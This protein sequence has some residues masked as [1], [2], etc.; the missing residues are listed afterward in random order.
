MK[1]SRLFALLTT[2]LSSVAGFAA[3]SMPLSISCDTPAGR[4]VTV[5]ALTP[6]IIRVDNTHKGQ[7]AAPVQSVLPI[8]AMTGTGTMLK[9]G[10]SF[11]TTTGVRATLDMGVL[12][13]RSHGAGTAVTDNLARLRNAD[14]KYE[15]SLRTSGKGSFYGA[16][17]RGHSLNLRGDTLVMY[18]RQNYGYTGSDPRISQMNITM[19]LFLS[20]DGYAIVFDD[21]AAAEL[22]LSDPIK[23]ITESHVPVTYYY[24]SGVENLADLTE[25]LTTITGRQPLPPLW[26]L[27]YITS[28]YGYRTQAQTLGTVDTLKSRGYPLDGIVLDLYWYGVE[29]DMGRLAW[30]PSQWPDH[31]AMLDSLRGMGVNLVAISQ[32][33]VLRNGRAIDNYN[34]LAPKGFF[35][36]DSTG[37]APQEVK[38]WVGEG[39]MFDVSNPDTRAWLRERYRTLTDD[40]ITGWWGDLGEPEVHPENAMHANGLNARL[41]HNKYGNDWS[42]IISELFATEY[43]DRRLMT[44]MRGGTTGLQRH[45]V[46]PWSTDVSRSWGGL[47]PQVRI[48]LNSGLSGMGYMSSDLGGFAV[49]PDNAYMPELYVRWLQSGLFSPVFR[50]HAQ[51][52]AEPYNYPQYE[53]IIRNI[54]LER[55]RW[56]P[57]NYTL[58]Y[59]NASTGYPLVRPLDFETPAAGKYDNIS[60][61]YMWGSEL[62][63]APVMTEGATSRRVVFP[64]GTTWYDYR[65]PR[66]SYAGGTTIEAYPAPLDV[67]PL[68][69]RQGAFIPTADYRMENTAGYR[70][71]RFTVNYYPGD[72]S[73]SAYTLYDDNRISP[74][75][76]A[77][78][79]YRLIKFKGSATDKDIHIEVSSKGSYAGAPAEIEL[80]FAVNTLSERPASVSV[81]GKKV[82]FDYDG[83]KGTAA[84][85]VR[86]IPGKTTYI[87]IAR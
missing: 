63:V 33:Y 81:G 44:L 14:G 45:S 30:E 79:E 8:E 7:P 55:Y 23:Y 36:A 32:P 77:D 48:M 70:A 80:T 37:K 1:I 58:A 13:L 86:F 60:D 35:V 19:P 59:E 28:K 78:G 71:D 52:Y 42:S 16:G 25:Q 82:K 40:G 72:K 5:T 62:M 66:I 12:H 27:G 46:F 85:A 64:D 74:V 38:I 83:E 67:L 57:Y 87:T 47:E 65:D 22:I 20:A 53:D 49:D 31:K 76:L 39:G 2:L 41:Y 34:E 15:I 4:T 75:A 43:P 54:V 18:N 73:T 26:A 61:Q 9:P 84:F 69:V 3:D 50:T 29:E 21:Y 68:F 10:K 51:Q 6:Y 17:E 24:I 11:V 56:L